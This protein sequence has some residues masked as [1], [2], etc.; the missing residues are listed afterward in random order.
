MDIITQVA[1]EGKDLYV[2]QFRNAAYTFVFHGD[3]GLDFAVDPTG[4]TCTNIWDP[5][6]PYRHPRIPD[7]LFDALAEYFEQGN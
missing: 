2:V 5:F 6:G 7:E 3:P 4:Y 1:D